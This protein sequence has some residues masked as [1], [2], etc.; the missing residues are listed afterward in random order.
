[1]RNWTKLD[2]SDWNLSSGPADV[3]IQVPSLIPTCSLR[4]EEAHRPTQTPR[5]C[6]SRSQHRWSQRP[7]PHLPKCPQHA[8]HP[9]G[10]E[11][12]STSSV[13][14]G[15]TGELEF[16]WQQTGIPFPEN[17]LLPR[18]TEALKYTPQQAPVINYTI[19]AAKNGRQGLNS[20][21]L[22]GTKS[23]TR[24][25]VAYKSCKVS[26]VQITQLCPTLA[27]PWTAARQAPVS[28]GFSRQEYWKINKRY[29]A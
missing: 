17:W 11:G 7:L 26:E 5:H 29:G 28:M 27:N 15:A 24:R 2:F 22:G 16:I 19:R 3:K 14:Q 20:F 6:K 1:M 8:Q 21:Q 23:Y 12:F 25:D 9:H 18:P 13:Q 10:R 4:A